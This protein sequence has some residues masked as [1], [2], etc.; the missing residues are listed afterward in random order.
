MG[1]WQGSGHYQQAH[2]R[3]VSSPLYILHTDD[4]RSQYKNQHILEFADDSE[5]VGLLH[6]D[7]TNHGPVVKDF[8]HWCHSAFLQPNVTTTK[9]MCINPYPS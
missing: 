4:C 5:I 1:A 6:A 9:D 3:V 2:P 8:V 7:E